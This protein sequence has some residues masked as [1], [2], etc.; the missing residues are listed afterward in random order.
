MPP[1]P[2]H[3]APTCSQLSMTCSAWRS[4][5][6]LT[7][8]ASGR[9]PSGPVR[10]IPLA[11]AVG[12]SAGSTTA[13]NGTQYTSW[14]SMAP[15][16]ARLRLSGEL[17]RWS[18]KVWANCAFQRAEV[19]IRPHFLWSGLSRQIR[20][21]DWPLNPLALSPPRTSVTWRSPSYVDTI[22]SL[23]P[24]GRSRIVE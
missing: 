6:V 9:S 24:T 11:T 18:Q 2:P 4:L 22:S 12:T 19:A 5:S 20:F 16:R 14:S 7:T 8:G 10:P 3:V 21:S 17:C 15:E 1:A 13:A 23:P